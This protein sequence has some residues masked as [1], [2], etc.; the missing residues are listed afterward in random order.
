MLALS[1][2][3]VAPVYAQDSS[4]SEKTSDAWNATKQTTKNA[5]H[6]V[7]DKTREA[8]KAVKN[9]VSSGKAQQAD[10]NMTDHNI[11]MAK[12]FSP[13]EVT[14]SIKNSG[15]VAHKFVITGGGLKDVGADVGPGQSG[16]VRVTLG[17]GTYDAGCGLSEH[18]GKEPHQR[19]T[20]K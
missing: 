11:S 13:G 2:F 5:A 12:T 7:A 10:V 3:C 6:T 4:A 15:Q 17:A 14:F 18:V 1:S 16:T 9:G 19:I 8:G 20:V